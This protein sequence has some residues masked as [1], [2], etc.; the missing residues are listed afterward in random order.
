MYEVSMRF[1]IID[2]IT[3]TPN[4]PEMC[5]LCVPTKT[6]LGCSAFAVKNPS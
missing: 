6:S 1:H 3:I 2:A 5:L 4:H